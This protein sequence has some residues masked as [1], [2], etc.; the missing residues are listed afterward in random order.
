VRI[1]EAFETGATIRAAGGGYL[2][3][4]IPG[5]PADR[6]SFGRQRS[7][8]TIIETI[9][10]RGVKLSFVPGNGSRPAMLVA[11]SARVRTGANGR[12]RVSTA[13]RT[14]AG[15]FAQGA[16]SIPLFWLVPEAKMPKRLN[17]NREFE[18][19]TASFMAEFSKA[20]AEE[21]A[22]LGRA[23]G[24]SGRRGRAR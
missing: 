17:W 12:E 18:R 23:G 19:A 10:A 13:A 21:F 3:I 20:F 24:S 11:E 8:E 9:R 15:R 22:A 5:S 2:A 4:P 1:F 16:A 6:R 14:A 7:G